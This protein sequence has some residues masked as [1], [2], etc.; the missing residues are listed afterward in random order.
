MG[1]IYQLANEVVVWLGPE[2]DNSKGAIKLITST[3][4]PQG[5]SF[6]S[7]LSANLDHAAPFQAILSLAKRDY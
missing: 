6:L 2:K 3:V 5:K 4:E 1:K 7:D